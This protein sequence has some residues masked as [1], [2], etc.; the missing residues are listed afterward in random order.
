[1][2]LN[3]QEA[4]NFLEKALQYSKADSITLSLSGLIITY[5]L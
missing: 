4:K 5:A 3:E 1:M 2:I